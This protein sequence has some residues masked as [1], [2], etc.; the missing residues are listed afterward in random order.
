LAIASAALAMAV[1]LP[2]DAA[3]KATLPDIQ[4]VG[5]DNYC[6]SFT[7]TID[8]NGNTTLT[9][10]PISTTPP[11]AGAPTGCVAT[12]NGTSLLSVSLTSAGGQATLLVSCASP[13]SGI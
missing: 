7:T 11:P 8:S 6:D 5:V 13:T 12:I 2:A 9:C 3:N 1:T 10:V 4:V